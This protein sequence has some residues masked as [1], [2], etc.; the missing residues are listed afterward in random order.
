M[1]RILSDD[2]TVEDCMYALEDTKWDVHLAIKLLKL[3]QL[4]STGLADKNH[5][6]KILLRYQWNVEEAANYLLANP[7]GSESPEIVHM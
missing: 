1:R 7:P 6:K 3:K 4:L 5:S 2:V